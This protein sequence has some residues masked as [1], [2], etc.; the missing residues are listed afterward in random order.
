MRSLST[1]SLKSYKGEDPA[2]NNVSKKSLEL[3]LETGEKAPQ[4]VDDERSSEHV[5]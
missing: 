2:M 5:T 3:K 4:L 1:L